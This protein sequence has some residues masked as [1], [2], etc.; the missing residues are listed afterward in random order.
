M[1]FTLSVL[2]VARLTSRE[3]TYEWP[4][5]DLF[6]PELTE[7]WQFPYRHSPYGTHQPSLSHKSNLGSLQDSEDW[8]I[9]SD[10]WVHFPGARHWGALLRELKPHPWVRQQSQKMLSSLTA[11]FVAVQVRAGARVHS[12]TQEHSPVQWYIDRM[13]QLQQVRPKL[14]FF[15]SSDSNEAQR[16]IQIAVPSS[17]GFQKSGGYNTTEGV[18]EGMA[19]LYV[20]AES[21]HILGAHYSSF[22]AMAWLLGKKRMAIET[23]QD[24][25][26]ARRKP[27]HPHPRW[28]DIPNDLTV[29]KG[30]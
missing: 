22:P 6:Q 30:K 19:D 14:Q 9:Q 2:E 21:A 15:I 3:F 12:R 17:Y 11:P 24:L 28:L 20:M 4:T 29:L 25:R 18:R 1:R 5:G 10:D 8:V 7:L 27:L 23:S 13:R 16:E 26:P